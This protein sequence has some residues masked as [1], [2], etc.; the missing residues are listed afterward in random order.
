MSIPTVGLDKQGNDI[1][2]YQREPLSIANYKEGDVPDDFIVVEVRL[3][4]MRKSFMGMTSN[5]A[6]IGFS[7]LHIFKKSQTVRD[8]RIRLYEIVRPLLGLK[9]SVSSRQQLA[10]EYDDRFKKADGSYRFSNQ[11]YDVEI[12]NN[13]PDVPNSSGF[14]SGP[15]KVRCDFCLC[16]HKDNCMFAFEDNVLLDD[17]LAVMQHKRDLE[18]TINWKP[19]AKVNLKAWENPAYD[20]VNL[21]APTKFDAAR[22]SIG[23]KDML[24]GDDMGPQKEDIISIYDCLACFG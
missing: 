11:Y 14:F 15:T 7:R 2:V 1:V 4:Q 22:A 24:N 19:N 20:R 21:N 17:V 13:L 8:V 18:L 9:T 23:G 6:N 5:L 3:V 10:N 16:D 12:Q